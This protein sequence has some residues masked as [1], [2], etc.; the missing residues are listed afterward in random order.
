LREI[1]E[2]QHIGFYYPP[3]DVDTLVDCIRKLYRDAALYKR[4]S[5][6]A[7]KVFGQICDADKIYDEY[8]RHVEMVANDYKHRIE[9]V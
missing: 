1:I 9:G 2:T 7:R 3:N 8:A 6:N 4:M 5:E